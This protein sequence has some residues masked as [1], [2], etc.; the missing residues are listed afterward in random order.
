MIIDKYRIK[1]EIDIFENGV[2][3]FDELSGT[4]KTRLAG[5]LRKYRSYGENVAAYSYED[6]SSGLALNTLNKFNNAVIM[7]DRYDL[8]APD[9]IE[10]IKYLAKH[11]IVLIDYKGSGISFTEDDNYCS[12]ELNQNKIL[13]TGW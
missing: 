7:I 6:Y 5:L 9:L 12:I 13:V 3:I 4:G 8:M 2:Y 1:I 10:Q 11:N